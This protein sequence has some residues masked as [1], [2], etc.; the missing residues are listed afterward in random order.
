MRKLTKI[1]TDNKLM[2]NITELQG[3][4]SLGRNTADQIGQAAGAVVHVG[5]RKLYRV[6][7][8]EAYI[9]EMGEATA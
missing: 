1:D 4:L 8:V 5:R 2:V 7:R 9:N 6:D 3:M